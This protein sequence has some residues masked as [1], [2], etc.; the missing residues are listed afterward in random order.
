MHSAAS[1]GARG[2]PADGCSAPSQHLPTAPTPTGTCSTLDDNNPTQSNTITPP[3]G[4]SNAASLAEETI[5][6]PPAVTVGLNWDNGAHADHE[7]PR[8][9]GF[10]RALIRNPDRAPPD[11][12]GRP[13]CRSAGPIWTTPPSPRSPAGSAPVGRPRVK[14]PT[15]RTCQTRRRR[16]GIGRPEPALP[17]GD[18]RLPR[19]WVYRGLRV[20]RRRGL[21]RPRD[22]RRRR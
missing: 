20:L 15:P 11:G 21:R 2:Q 12:C 14:D 17:R 10:P 13:E 22:L 8:T 6:A 3:P 18:G 7:D 16:P 5:D 1:D 4:R 9:R 19:A